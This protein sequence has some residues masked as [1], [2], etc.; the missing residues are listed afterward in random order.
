MKKRII[1]G[2]IL[3]SLFLLISCTSQTETAKVIEKKEVAKVEATEKE[4][5]EK[6]EVAKVEA[7]E[8]VK[9]TVDND[10][11]SKLLT[12]SKDIKN[13]AFLYG[14]PETSNLFKDTFYCL[15]SD[16]SKLVIKIYAGESYNVDDY[17]DKAFVSND[18]AVGC[19]L[20][21]VRCRSGKLDNLGKRFDV[22]KK[23]LFIPKTPVEWISF[24]S[25]MDA[26]LVGKSTFNN[27]VVEDYTF[28]DGEFTYRI[29]F[30]ERFG[31][32]HV[33]EKLN[34]ELKIEKYQFNDLLFNNWNNDFF[35]MP[36]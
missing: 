7:T 30:D 3:V 33:I 5:V 21:R 31:V 28:N 8:K 20:D 23:S 14:G 29:K 17:Y 24:F 15:G 19:C 10:V 26:E 27:R 1:I 35:E 34:G 12:K 22:E 13:Y 9:D 32:P 11:V 4:V 16:C 36:C 2:L 18:E 25:D 6:K